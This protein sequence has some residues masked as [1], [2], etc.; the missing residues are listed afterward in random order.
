MKS[1]I[2]ILLA[3]L[4]WNICQAQFYKKFDFEITVNNSL[5]VNKGEFL[6]ETVSYG[7]SGNTQT[8]DS[9]KPGFYT[10]FNASIGFNINA[11][12]AIRLRYGTNNFGAKISGEVTYWSDIGSQ[13]PINVVNFKHTLPTRYW[14]IGYEYKHLLKE[15][16]ILFG[17]QLNRQNSKFYD[18]IFSFSGLENTNYALGGYV[19]YQKSIYKFLSFIG[20]LTVHNS[21]GSK[22]ERTPV[23][24]SKFIPIQYGLELGIKVGFTN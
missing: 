24:E 1:T 14:S 8:I 5:V 22:V 7:L 16:C 23:I 20:K 9:Q 13:A 6:S 21:Y 19:G 17:I 10:N 15:N 2:L 18:V 4:T 11:N 12:H 3:G